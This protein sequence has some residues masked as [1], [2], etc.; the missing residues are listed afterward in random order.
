MPVSFT[1]AGHSAE[2]VVL[3]TAEVEGLT[4]E[5]ILRKAC[6]HQYL[7]ADEVLRSSFTEADEPMPRKPSLNKRLSKLNPFTKSK[8][9][10]A[11]TPSSTSVS[12]VKPVLRPTPNGLVHTA[13]SAYNK[14]HNLVLR[15]D[16][17]WL[18][19]LTQFNFFVDA[20]AE[21][22]RAQFVAHEGTQEVKVSKQQSKK[23]MDF[24]LMAREMVGLLQQFI[25]DPTLRAWVLPSFSTT[26]VKDTTVGAIIMM[27]TLKA[28]FEYVF[29]SIECGIPR[30]TLEGTKEDWEDI[31]GRL[32]KLKEYGVQTTAWYHLLVPVI[33]RFVAAFDAP[34]S[35]PNVEF[36]QQIAHFVPGGSGPSYYS[37]W[38]TAFCVFNEEGGWIGLPLRETPEGTV[39]PDSLSAK[40]FWARY[41]ESGR[42]DYTHRTRL[43][44]D[45]TP[46]HMV[47]ANNIPS[48]YVEVPVK[49]TEQGSSIVDPCTMIAGVV[50]T[51]A[52]C[53]QGGTVRDTV[54]PVTGWWMFTNRTTPRPWTN[55]SDE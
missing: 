37:G 40:Q 20:N 44:Y 43:T 33:S 38:I 55:E 39:P 1:V 45:D 10:T 18:S 5:A 50:G 27:A 51:L 15:P 28:Y 6:A 16:D 54:Q 41:G 32:E 17:I 12:T 36:W 49:L 31:L 48:N 19:I 8:P 25:V 24:G 7:M 34:D 22:L 46:F 13:I 26:T 52:S 14:H 53:G 3:T 35:K 21:L 23:E 42:Y 4:P 9:D 2:P 47:E 29:E 30:V 11:P